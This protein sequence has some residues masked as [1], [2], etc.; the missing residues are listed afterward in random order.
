M[1]AEGIGMQ[2]MKRQSMACIDVRSALLEIVYLL[3]PASLLGLALTLPSLLLS[4]GRSLCP[5]YKSHLSCSDLHDKV[6]I[7]VDF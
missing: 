6:K 4:C 3:T 5:V 7:G 1:D 2:S